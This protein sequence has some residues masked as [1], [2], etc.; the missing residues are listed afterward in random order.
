VFTFCAQHD[1]SLANKS[2]RFYRFLFLFLLLF[3]S[4]I[5]KIK[6]ALLL[7]L[8]KATFVFLSSILL[9]DLS[10]LTPFKSYDPFYVEKPFFF[11]IIFHPITLYKSSRTLLKI[12]K[13][14][15]AYDLINYAGSE[16]EVIFLKILPKLCPYQVSYKSKKN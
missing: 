9:S 10:Q 15:Y 7:M 16:S 5:K 4:H 6:H 13:N 1:E 8:F 2:V 14:E 3:L 12:V 11:E